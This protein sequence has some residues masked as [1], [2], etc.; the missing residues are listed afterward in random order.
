MNVELIIEW[1]NKRRDEK[2]FNAIKQVRNHCRKLVAI[3]NADWFQDEVR[4]TPLSI[5]SSEDNT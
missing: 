3:S 2:D 4:T 1:L 5:H